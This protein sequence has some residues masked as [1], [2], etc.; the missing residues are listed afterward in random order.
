[1]TVHIERRSETSATDAE[2]A[3]AELARQIKVKVGSSCKIS[4]EEPG[5][6]ARSSGKL[7]RIYD[8][9]PR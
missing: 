3:G 2:A 1:M 9:R 8:Q 5:S 4:V 7:R 6:L